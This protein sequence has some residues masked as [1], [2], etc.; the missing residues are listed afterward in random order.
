M[1]VRISSFPEGEDPDSYSKKLPTEEFKKYLTTVSLNFVDYLIKIY[2]LNEET[3]PDKIINI[4]KKI[5]LSLAEIPDVF[6]REEYCK[7]YYTKGCKNQ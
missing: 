3:D 6:S 4:K 1:N 5:I 2:G 7:I